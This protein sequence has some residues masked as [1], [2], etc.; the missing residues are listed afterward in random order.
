MLIDHDTAA[1]E[2][3]AECPHCHREW[4][5]DDGEVC[6]EPWPHVECPACGEWI[7]LF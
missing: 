1:R 5:F 4:L 3:Y 7:P 6:L 2:I